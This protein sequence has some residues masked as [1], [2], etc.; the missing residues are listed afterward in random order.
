VNTFSEFARRLRYVYP[1]AFQRGS[2]EARAAARFF[3]RAAAEGGTEKTLANIQDAAFRAGVIQEADSWIA[4]LVLPACAA[5]NLK[6]QKTSPERLVDEVRVFARTVHELR[7]RVD[8][9]EKELEALARRVERADLL[10][11][12]I[13]DGECQECA[14]GPGAPCVGVHTWS[15]PATTEAVLAALRGVAS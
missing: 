5:L 2:I 15:I 1:A 3:Q 6:P 4:R 8:A 7:A 14:S 13:R 11:Q 10:V 9:R 12:C